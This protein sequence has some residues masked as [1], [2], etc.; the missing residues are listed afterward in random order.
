MGL[1][2][3]DKWLKDFGDAY[4]EFY[5]REHSLVVCQCDPLKCRDVK[6][7]I[8]SEKILYPTLLGDITK[9]RHAFTQ[10]G[11]EF[12][13]ISNVVTAGDPTPVTGDPPDECTA[14]FTCANLR[15]MVNF[16]ECLRLESTMRGYAITDRARDEIRA[17]FA[18]DPLIVPAQQLIWKAFPGVPDSNGIDTTIDVPFENCAGA[19][20]VFPKT[21]NQLTVFENPMLRDFYLKIDNMQIPDR[22]WNTTEPRYFQ[23]QIILNDLDGQL[24]A[25]DV[26]TDSIINAKNEPSTGLRYGNSLRDDT[27]FLATFQTERVD[28]GYTFDGYSSAN[29]NANVQLKGSAI[30]KDFPK[31]TYLYPFTDSTG[32][33]VFAVNHQYL[34]KR[35]TFGIPEKCIQGY[36]GFILR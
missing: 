22:E 28:S 4:L 3:F 36:P 17:M 32:A 14:T 1:Q 18:A 2:C 27:Q 19:I 16:A 5:F 26:F 34:F 12:M 23:E 33:V 7:Y 25:T 6:Q 10:V 24:Q 13:G 9:F 30:H 21:S 11:D 15:C 29:A 20:C 35:L 31:N 8:Q